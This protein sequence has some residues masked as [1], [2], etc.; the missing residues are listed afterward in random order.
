MPPPADPP[1]TDSGTDPAG[2]LLERFL[3]LQGAGDFAAALPLIEALAALRPDNGRLHGYHGFTL[4]RLGRAADALAAY[5]RAL[6]LDP[7][8]V[9]ARF[10]RACLLARLED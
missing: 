6:A 3:A 8:Y 1:P 7:G 10:N 9:D 5:A 2:A 4:E